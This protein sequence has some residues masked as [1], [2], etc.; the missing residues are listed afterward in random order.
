MA[1]GGFHGGSSH[2]G[3]H[4]GGGGGFSGGGGGFSG[5]GFGGFGGGSHYSGGG[6][7]GRSGNDDDEDMGRHLVAYLIFCGVVVVGT[8]FSALF[9]LV[10]EGEVPGFNYGNLTIFF[11]SG[12]FYFFSLKD[13]KRTSVIKEFKKGYLPTVYGCV[14]KGENP[15]KRI[16]DGKTWYAPVDKRY[17]IAFYDREYGVDNA[18]KVMETINRTPKIIWVLPGKWLVFG[19]ISFISSF[20]FY[21]LVIPVFE[22]AIMT[23]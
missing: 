5:G 22:N 10:G 15:F 6:F 8:V 4:H 3:G 18:E 16:G 11:G 2:S 23:D 1:G 21:E 9:T 14:W 17:R 13:S 19:I 12:F 20:F 7:Y